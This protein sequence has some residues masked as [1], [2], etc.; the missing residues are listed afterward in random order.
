MEKEKMNKKTLT[1]NLEALRASHLYGTD[2]SVLLGWKKVIVFCN[3]SD[4]ESAEDENQT[5]LPAFLLLH[6]PRPMIQQ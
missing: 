2:W 3:Q 4:R 5:S 6:G 1:A